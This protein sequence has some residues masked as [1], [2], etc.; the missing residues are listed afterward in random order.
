MAVL[1]AGFAAGF[2]AMS[3]FLPIAFE[4]GTLRACGDTESTVGHASPNNNGF[5]D[6]VHNA[7]SC[8]ARAGRP[9]RHTRI[10][11][12]TV[13]PRPRSVVVM[14]VWDISVLVARTCRGS[15]CRRRG[16]P[17]MAF[18]PSGPARI[19][20]TGALHDRASGRRDVRTWWSS[21]L[22]PRKANRARTRS[23]CPRAS[24]VARPCALDVAP[25]PHG[26]GGQGP[27]F[28]ESVI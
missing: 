11:G 5:T 10:A 27:R 12:E 16:H 17:D 9:I 15:D 6:V 24:Q 19:T 13:T 4:D 1:A 7:A 23:I 21:S 20:R 8:E 22:S 28:L 18:E 2:L 3:K 25:Q 14:W 26:A